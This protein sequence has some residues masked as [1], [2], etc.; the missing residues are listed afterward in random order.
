MVTQVIAAVTAV[1]VTVEVALVE[2]DVVAVLLT[3]V[4][5]VLD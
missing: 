4:V 1:E 3:E 2:T 5:A